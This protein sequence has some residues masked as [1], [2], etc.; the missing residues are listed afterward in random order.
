[1]K[2]EPQ[3][4]YWLK[5][6]GGIILG[7]TASAVFVVPAALL[8]GIPWLFALALVAGVTVLLT[9]VA[10]YVAR[11]P[12]PQGSHAEDSTAPVPTALGGPPPAEPFRGRFGAVGFW[13]IGIAVVIPAFASAVSAV[14]RFVVAP[15]IAT[16]LA[17]WVQPDRTQAA[18]AL[19]FYVASLA[20]AVLF[21]WG[22]W[23][24]FRAT[25]TAA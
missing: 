10:L 6:L 17:S 4:P 9:P 22:A 20:A 5:P 15:L 19:L 8:V 25:R 3:Q 13:V 14:G 24:R 18:V 2:S 23:R 1:M 11:H 7:F 16:A 21:W 12:P